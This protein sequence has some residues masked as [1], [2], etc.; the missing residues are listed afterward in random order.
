M[1]SAVFFVAAHLALVR[2]APM[3]SSASVAATIEQM[4]AE[5][6]VAPGTEIL[7]YGDQAFGSSIPFYLGQRVLLVDGRSTSL[8]FGSTF[9]D[10]P[11]IFVSSAELS[12]SGVGDRVNCCLFRSSS[13]PRSTNFWERGLCW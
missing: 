11:K 4:R 9:A 2:F 13:A 10:A 6:E 8:W 1:T 12:G 5:G 7:L 3:L